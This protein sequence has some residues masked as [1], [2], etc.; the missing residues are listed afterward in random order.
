M[1]ITA[2]VPRPD[3]TAI[4]YLASLPSHPLTFNSSNQTEVSDLIG[5]F[6][7]IGL[8]VPASNIFLNSFLY[9]AE[10][11]TPDETSNL[12]RP[13]ARPS[14]GPGGSVPS[15]CGEM[16]YPKP[17]RGSAKCKS[18][19]LAGTITPFSSKRKHS[20][21]IRSRNQTTMTK[22]TTDKCDKEHGDGEQRNDKCDDKRSGDGDQHH[23][24]LFLCIY[25]CS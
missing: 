15:L 25:F 19:I 24:G 8:R 5:G 1:T 2:P 16:Q 3:P 18:H 21:A 22:M 9:S 20:R 17:S 7:P 6:E 11:S 13:S 23:D 4:Q 14:K 12:I 10:H